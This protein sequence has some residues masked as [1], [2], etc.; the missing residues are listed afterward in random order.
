[1][2]EDKDEEAERIRKKGVLH[3]LTHK[4]T[5]AFSICCIALGFRQDEETVEDTD[6]AEADVE[7]GEHHIMD[8][9]MD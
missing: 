5:N 3:T 2:K 8:G 4:V 6:K 1:M 9:L 7:E